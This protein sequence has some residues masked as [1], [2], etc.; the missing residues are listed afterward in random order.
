MVISVK[1]RVVGRMGYL[2]LD[3][4]HA[5]R[6]IELEETT[7]AIQSNPLPSRKHHQSIPDRWLSSLMLSRG[8]YHTQ[9]SEHV[10]RND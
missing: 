6:I 8:W 10:E 4:K 7:R 1:L 2:N 5:H 3:H 9:H